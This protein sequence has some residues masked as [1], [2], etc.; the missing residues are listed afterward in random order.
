MF[1][2]DQL[3]AQMQ[4]MGIKA[5]D[6]VLVHT[7]LR[8]VGPVEGGADAIID[9]FCEYLSDG[10]FIVPTHTWDSVNKN[11]PVFDVRTAVPC[12]GTLPKVAAF[13]KDGVRSLHP[14]HSVWAHGK[15][16]AEYVANEGD[17]TSPAPTWY[18]WDR[19]AD[20]NAKILLI[21]VGH[22]RNTFIHSV[23]E[24][25]NYPDRIS[26]ESFEVTVIDQE[27]RSF[28]HPMHW[29]R[30][31]RTTDVSQFY[32]NF[33]KPLIELGAQTSGELG[34]AF[35]RVVDAKKCREIVSRIYLRARDNDIFTEHREIP[36]ELY[37]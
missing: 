32:P 2:K 22:N 27:G 1:T 10:L 23:D 34:N 6:T 20:M 35:V 18:G 17:A 16:A 25:C 12:I 15:N 11:H 8:A 7:S 5:D 3:K 21:G 29:H 13:R 37:R 4:A 14:T 19:L 28:T 30:C 26:P 31:S 36:E 24:R 9:A 33:E